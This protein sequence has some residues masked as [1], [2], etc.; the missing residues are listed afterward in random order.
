[1]MVGHVTKDGSIAGPRVLEHLVDVVLHFEGERS[2]RLRMVRAVKNRF[3]PVDEVG[4]FDLSS[5]GIVAVTDPSGLFVARH[6][7]PVP[8]TCVSVVLEGRRPILAEVQALVTPATAERPRRATSGLDGSRIAM[9]VAV[10]SQRSRIRLHNHDVFASTVGGVRIT[11]PA[12]DLAAAVA[13]ASA[14]KERDVPTDLVVIGELGLAG[15]LRRVRDTPQRLA[16]AARLGFKGAIVPA[17][18]QRDAGVVRTVDGM[19]VVGAPDVDAAL[20]VLDLAATDSTPLFRVHRSGPGR[21]VLGI[22]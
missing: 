3:G 22:V 20:R 11:E 21:P 13:I 9:L 14:W 5:E 8:G 1:M 15:E 16:E 17:D 12:A 4:C 6:H 7:E 18:S 19:R 10:L 2:S